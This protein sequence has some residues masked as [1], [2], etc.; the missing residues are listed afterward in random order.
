MRMSRPSRF[1]AAL[2]ALVGML[3]MQLAVASYAC[4]GL[5][6]PQERH[7][8]SATIDLD[9]QEMASCAEKDL[10]QPNLCHAHNHAGEQSL[11]K[12]QTPPVQGFVATGLALPLYPAELAYRAATA[13]SEI[14]LLSHA[15]APPMAI[16]NCCFRI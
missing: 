2:I 16:R 13:P 14:T 12:P 9:M 6:V 11:D 3:F 15:T 5:S 1:I 7:E 10:A 4:P 8:L